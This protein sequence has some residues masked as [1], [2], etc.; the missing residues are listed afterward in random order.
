MVGPRV[1]RLPALNGAPNRGN[2][3][4]VLKTASA[5]LL[6]MA[7]AAPFVAGCAANAMSLAGVPSGTTTIRVTNHVNAPDQLDKLAITVDGETLSLSAV[8]PSGASAASVS[9]LKL[10]PGAHIIAVRASARTRR[11]TVVVGAQQAFHVTG[12]PAAI[13]VDVRSVSSGSRAETDVTLG[14]D[15]PVAVELAING[16]RLD[17]AFGAARNDDKE[18]RCGPLLTI[19]KAICR[20]AADLDAATR[21][22]DV[23]TTLCVQDKLAAMRKLAMIADTSK[24]DAAEMAARD[25]TLLSQQVDY[26]VG[27]DVVV[28]DGL[29]RTR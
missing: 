25:V 6:A 5:A 21:R 20:A 16:G 10:S 2:R 28:Q 11:D 13:V 24:G 14:L 4:G 1:A 9:S 29:T 22:R 7:L 18:V 17:P 19:P 26:C 15:E 23:V 12:G 27:Q 8:P 3:G